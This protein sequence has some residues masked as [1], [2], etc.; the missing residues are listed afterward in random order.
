MMTNMLFIVRLDAQVV[1]DECSS[2]I[3]VSGVT[4]GQFYCIDGTTKNAQPDLEQYSPCNTSGF[5]VVWY[6]ITDLYFSTHLSLQVKGDEDDAFMLQLYGTTSDCDELYSIPLTLNEQYCMLSLNGSVDLVGKQ[7]GWPTYYVAVVGLRASGFDFTFCINSVYEDYNCGH[8]KALTVTRDAGIEIPNRP[9]STGE[10]LTVSM[11]VENFRSTENGCQ[12]FQGLVPVFGTGWADEFF[13]IKG[14][15]LQSTLNQESTHALN[16]G[17]YQNSTWAW[18]TDVD[19][20]HYHPDYQVGYFDA[21][22]SL[23]ICNGIYQKDCE[24]TGGLN[25]GCCTPCW[26]APK[27]TTLPG[28]WFA[29]GINGT[30]P[31]PGPPIGVDWGDGNSCAI[32]EGPWNFEF[33]LKIKP[34]YEFQCD[35]DDFVDE[36]TLGFFTF[37][38]RE[39]GGWEGNSN[40][41]YNA[42][43]IETLPVVCTGGGPPHETI[44]IHA[45]KGDSVVIRPSDYFPS[46]ESVLFWGMYT[47]SPF[48]DFAEGYLPRNDSFRV[49][50]TNPSENYPNHIP[51][52]VYGY[53]SPQSVRV[54]CK[55]E[56]IVHPEPK[57]GFTYTLN[58]NKVNFRSTHRIDTS[59]FWDFGD[60][61]YST[62][63]DPLHSY[64]QGGIYTVQQIVSNYCGSD[65][66]YQTIEINIPP[67]VDF[68]FSEDI[69]CQ[70]D[71]LF[72]TSTNQDTQ[73]IYQWIIDGGQPNMTDK[74]EI[75][76]I[77]PDTGYFDIGLIVTSPFGTDTLQI[78]SA[79]HV[80]PHVDIDYDVEIYDS[81]YLFNFLGHPDQYVEWWL[82]DSLLMAGPN[83]QHIFD[84]AGHYQITIKAYNECGI[85]S[86]R[87]GLIIM[88]VSTQELATE[89]TISLHPNPAMDWIELFFDRSISAN[90]LVLYDRFGHQVLEEKIS[91]WNDSYVLS[92][93]G[94]LPRGLFILGIE[95]NGKMIYKKFVLQ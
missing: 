63:R 6:K 23:D 29:Y 48:L 61:T 89:N 39:V 8:D 38:E 21:N 66:A 10:T 52:F 20:H 51:F 56:I 95:I 68:T 30:C 59:F 11:N 86:I 40:C 57:A 80:I 32:N 17:V 60:S 50:A 1:N 28:G 5:P 94:D 35:P 46:L 72:L 25:G 78:H 69:I 14:E 26:G 76:V 31:I 91:T 33:Q 13:D 44:R 77:Y 34:S 85:D 15:P 9:F 54:I 84:S 41:W 16:N 3:V 4:G 87:F 53:A 12:W 37:A 22:A 62:L 45:C 73:Y 58:E 71:T 18:F 27:G 65:T 64:S 83:A 92:G 19:Y 49:V 70:G 75:W 36:L 55:F 79:V 47:T 43:I 67:I 90:R 74:P 2:A 81:L 88:T 82:D 42:P 93:L 7:I 24:N